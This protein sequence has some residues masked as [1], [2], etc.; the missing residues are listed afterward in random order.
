MKEPSAPPSPRRSA[1]GR[2]VFTIAGCVTV[3]SALA[4]LALIFIVQQHSAAQLQ[5]VLDSDLKGFADLYSQRRTIAVR[6]GMERRIAAGTTSNEQIFLLLDKEGKRLG[7]NVEILP[8]AL[9][10]TQDQWVNFTFQGRAYRGSATLLPGGFALMNARATAPRDGLLN[11]LIWGGVLVVIAIAMLALLAGWAI[12]RALLTRIERVNATA[13]TVE[14]GNLSA[15]VSPINTGD[16]FD[17]LASHMNRMLDRVQDLNRATLSLADHIAHELRTPFNRLRIAAHKLRGRAGEAD[18]DELV[19]LANSIDG[20][21]ENTVG[22]FEALLDITAAEADATNRAS[23]VPV[24]LRHVLEEVGE[25][26]EALAEEK[27]IT[28][29]L[30]ES[31]EGP[32]TVLGE[33]TLLSR[34]IANLLDNAIKF[35]PTGGKVSAGIGVFENRVTLA[36]VDTGPGVAAHM[37][38][39]IF[40]RFVRGN[41]VEP[42]APGH[43]LGL[44]L[45]KAI[46]VR[47]GA[48]IHLSKTGEERADKEFWDKLGLNGETG[49]LV[50]VM[51]PPFRAQP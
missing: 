1:L 25:L 50:E 3:L 48:R 9:A 22:I 26:Y 41:P 8:A 19:R 45:V 37:Q 46:A 20:E 14:A 4:A 47:H 32:F 27:G 30:H 35:T 43:G 28:L 42:T 24:D 21:V 51:F 44:P 40:Q 17:R 7:G 10:N 38:D 16:E 39:R 29:T 2:M 13:R 23:F 36:I 49:L 18:R 6:E 5:A 31:N 34:L 33:A 11:S 15:R 12:S